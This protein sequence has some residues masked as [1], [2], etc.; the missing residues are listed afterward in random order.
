M[1]RA[2]IQKLLPTG[3]R[4]PIQ[5]GQLYWDWCLVDKAMGIT[6]VLT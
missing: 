4:S 2:I 1:K 5:G 3:S 6:H